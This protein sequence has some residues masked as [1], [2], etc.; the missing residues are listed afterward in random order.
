MSNLFAFKVHK[1]ATMHSCVR[2]RQFTK[3][4]TII[5]ALNKTDSFN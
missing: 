4:M 3:R 1:L 5:M 2:Q